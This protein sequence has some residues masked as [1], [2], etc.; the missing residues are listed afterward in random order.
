MGVS[1]V[2]EHCRATNLSLRSPVLRL[3]SAVAAGVVRLVVPDRLHV[4]AA[5][6]S[7]EDFRCFQKKTE[8]A[9]LTGWQM[10]W[11]ARSCRTHPTATRDPQHTRCHLRGFQSCVIAGLAAVQKSKAKGMAGTEWKKCSTPGA[12]AADGSNTSEIK[13]KLTNVD[14]SVSAPLLQ[15]LQRCTR[16]VRSDTAAVKHVLTES[17]RVCGGSLDPRIFAGKI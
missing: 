6:A 14:D 3:K 16:I 2:R 7:F 1:C 10:R 11:A 4:A 5:A 8:R 12:D 17:C 9:A 15:Q 13:S